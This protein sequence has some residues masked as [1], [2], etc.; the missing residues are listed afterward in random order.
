MVNC[1]S[2]SLVN[3]QNSPLTCEAKLTFH[4]KDNLVHD[5]K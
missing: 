2:V 5:K 4:V 3:F 1:E